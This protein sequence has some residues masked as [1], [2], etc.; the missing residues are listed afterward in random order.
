MASGY[1]GVGTVRAYKERGRASDYSKLLQKGMRKCPRCE[2]ILRVDEFYG[3]TGY[4][5][6][7]AREYA[8]EH[9]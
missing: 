3:G 5:H 7:C 8:R 9:R 6:R 4:C 2:R 1:K